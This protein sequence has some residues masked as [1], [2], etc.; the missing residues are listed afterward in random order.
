[1]AQGIIF[2]VHVCELVSNIL[3]IEIYVY[4][5]MRSNNILGGSAS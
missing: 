5:K 3:L 1:M 4:V 2:Q